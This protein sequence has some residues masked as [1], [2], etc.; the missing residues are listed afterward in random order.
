[1]F[2]IIFFLGGGGERGGGWGGVALR[3]L[4]KNILKHGVGKD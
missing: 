2:K 1:M 4:Y 3:D